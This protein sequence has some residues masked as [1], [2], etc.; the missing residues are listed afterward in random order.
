MACVTDTGMGISADILDKVFDPFFTTKEHGKGTGLGLSTVLGI[1]RSHDGFV[2]FSSE[3]GKGSRF[4]VYLPAH[5]QPVEQVKPAPSGPIPR[6][7][8]ETILVIDDEAFI[9]DT[10]RIALQ[11]NGYKVR[12]AAD[13]AEAVALFRREQGEIAGIVVDVMMPVMDGAATIEALQELNPV[14]PIVA[15]SGLRPRGKL[16]EAIA[17]GAI[18]FLQKPY[19]NE[20]L[21]QI[22]AAALRRVPAI[23][24]ARPGSEEN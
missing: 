4:C 18:A 19:T 10:A 1:V 22:V 7:N 20:Q 5:S 6:G 23:A 21:L 11:E 9:L 14:L 16:A 15:S 13:G 8:G 3:V 2:D 24:S 12:T 17:A